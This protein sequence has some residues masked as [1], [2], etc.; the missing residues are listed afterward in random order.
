M[1]FLMALMM[2]KTIMFKYMKHP[3]SMGMILILMTVNLS[4]M[5]NMMINSPWMSYIL[6]IVM[7]G[8][9]L[10]LFIYMASIASNEM[11]KYSNKMMII[12]M[13]T[14]IWMTMIK[15]KEIKMNIKNQMNMEFEPIMTMAQMFDYQNSIIT[16]IMVMYLLLTMI[17]VMF[18]TKIQ[19]GPMRKKT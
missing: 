9:M 16:V 18:N 15:S 7:L 17:T 10:V 13:I 3:L 11:M 19:E 4:I 8:G 1:K 6:I 14:P 5:M 12:I 2:T